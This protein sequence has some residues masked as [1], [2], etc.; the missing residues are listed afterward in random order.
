M[1]LKKRLKIKSEKLQ[2]GKYNKDTWFKKLILGQ[3][4]AQKQ[5]AW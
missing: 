1:T 4:R 3:N 2:Q 5:I